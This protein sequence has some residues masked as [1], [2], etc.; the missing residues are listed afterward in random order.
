MTPST[1]QTAA[2]S[3]ATLPVELKQALR[4]ILDTTTKEAPRHPAQPIT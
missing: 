1:A 2:Q 3:L 4:A